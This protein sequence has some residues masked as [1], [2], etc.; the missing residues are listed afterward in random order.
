MAHNS[1]SILETSHRVSHTL[2][3]GNFHCCYERTY[4]DKLYTTFIPPFFYA[5][6]YWNLL[7]TIKIHRL[8]QNCVCI[9][10]DRTH[11]K[12]LPLK[13][14]C[15]LS[16]NKQFYLRNNV[17]DEYTDNHKRTIYH[18]YLRCNLIAKRYTYQM[19][20]IISKNVVFVTNLTSKNVSSAIDCY[21]SYITY[22]CPIR[23][24]R[25]VDKTITLEIYLLFLTTNSQ[26]GPQLN[27]WNKIIVKV[28]KRGILV[29]KITY[30]CC[31]VLHNM[32]TSPSYG[33][34]SKKLFEDSTMV[35]VKIQ[36]KKKSNNA[37]IVSSQKKV[38]GK[39]ITILRPSFWLGFHAL[40]LLAQENNQPM[41]PSHSVSQ[42]VR[43]GVSHE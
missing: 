34:N 18:I 38:K 20:S 5:S 43:M 6:P 12:Y 30:Q 32:T 39:E 25:S 36:S 16:I 27:L 33:I 23:N 26:L 21:I 31:F 42:L 11:T 10:I 22:A 13:K 28:I 19:L 40:N 1:H 41:E 29:Y 3:K 35:E 37:K 4:E 14:L 8:K 24:K 2:W 15:R 17:V 9:F 7:Y